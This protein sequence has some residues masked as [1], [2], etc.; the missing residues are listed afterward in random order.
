MSLD[1]N[2]L[3]S[4]AKS[5]VSI[6]DYYHLVM[7]DSIPIGAEKERC[8]IW[9]DPEN[10]DNKIEVSFDLQTG[11]LVRLDMDAEKENGVGYAC[12]AD[13]AKKVADSFL[14]K[15]NPNHASYKWVHIDKGRNNYY[16][17]YQEEVGGLPLPHTGCEVTVNDKRNIIKYGLNENLSGVTNRPS[18]PP[19]IIA[20]DTIRSKIIDETRI[21]LTIAA[22]H[23]SMYEIKET[24]DEYYLVYEPIS[25]FRV[26]DAVTGND[27]FGFEH[28]ITPPS[29]PIA[30]NE[31]GQHWGQTSQT[32]ESEQAVTIN[33]DDRKVSALEKQLGIHPEQY[34]QVKSKD[35]GERIH[36]LYKRKEKEEAE[37]LEQDALSVDAYM[38]RKWGN[39]LKNLDN[40]CMIQIEKSTGRLVGFNCFDRIDEGKP[41]LS[42]QQ[43]WQKAEQFLSQVFPD[44]HSYL[45]LEE[46]KIDPDEESR[47]REFFYLPVFIGGIPVNHER[48]MISVST[49]TGEICTYMGVSHEMIRKLAQHN[50]QQ[51]ISAEEA[52]E[53]YIDY[54]KIQLK[55]FIHYE[56]ESP[57]CK[58]VYKPSTSKGDLTD[59]RGD[60]QQRLRYIDACS[61]ELIWDKKM[62]LL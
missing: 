36:I 40:T 55:W 30:S 1:L 50:F 15:H 21:Q 54:M 19:S 5:I 25:E 29:H 7:E 11:Q 10:D 18:W 49:V 3:Q 34:V 17:T 9:E 8:F 60:Y 43:C 46:D 26:I 48:I 33:L 39:Q 38:K 42:R 13:E 57:V 14:L 35:D 37:E 6:P 20:A 32:N 56:E 59:D 24:K 53:R 47:L 28:Y 52:L 2:K 27:L 23:S 41:I 31:T 22:L 58:L 51:V 4:I 44:Y 16:I 45:Q 62:S 12:E 61:G